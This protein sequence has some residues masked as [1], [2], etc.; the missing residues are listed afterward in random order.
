MDYLPHITH[1]IKK[2]NLKL[3]FDQGVARGKE[4]KSKC[5]ESL[6]CI[7]HVCLTFRE[8]YLVPSLLYASK[9]GIITSSGNGTN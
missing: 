3:I 5:T 2:S 8:H 6:L 4:K 7:D 1:L 9:V